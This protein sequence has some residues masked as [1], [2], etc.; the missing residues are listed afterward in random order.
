MKCGQKWTFLHLKVHPCKLKSHT[1]KY[2]ASR[3]FVVHVCT[4]LFQK[5]IM[6]SSEKEAGPLGILM[7]FVPHV[8]MVMPNSFSVL[9]VCIYSKMSKRVF[10][11]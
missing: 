8:P 5:E 10:G 6:A 3:M 11:L 4:T 7:W 9:L 1:N 2:L